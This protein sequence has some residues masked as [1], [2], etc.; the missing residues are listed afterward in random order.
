MENS[1]RVI[2]F[3]AWDKINKCIR[4]VWGLNWSFDGKKLKSIIA[5]DP[6]INSE[7]MLREGDFELMQYTGLKDKKGKEIWEGDILESYKNM[8]FKEQGKQKRVVEFKDGAFTIV[9]VNLSIV[10]EDCSGGS[11]EPKVIGN[12]YEN[13]DLLKE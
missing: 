12:I 8:I 2:K 9:T 13:P 11:F 3:R 4:N 7:Y 5:V 6:V 1:N 10:T